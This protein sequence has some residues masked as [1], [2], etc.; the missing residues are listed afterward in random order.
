LLFLGIS[1]KYFFIFLGL[2]CHILGHIMPFLGH[3]CMPVFKLFSNRN[4]NPSDDKFVLIKHVLTGTT[5][6]NQIF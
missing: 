2:F 6:L 5:P 4:P 1:V 3:K